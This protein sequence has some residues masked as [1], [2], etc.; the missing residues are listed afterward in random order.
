[1]MLYKCYDPFII[2]SPEQCI[3]LWAK[4]DK[5]ARRKCADIHKKLDFYNAPVRTVLKDWIVEEYFVYSQCDVFICYPKDL[6]RASDVRIISVPFEISNV[7]EY[8]MNQLVEMESHEENFREYVN[9]KS[10]NMSFNERFYIDS[11]GWIFDPY[12]NSDES[13]DVRED[14]KVRILEENSNIN[15]YMDDLWHDNVHDF[16]EDNE[17]YRDIFIE[18]ITTDAEPD[19]LDEGFYFYVCKELMEL[20]EWVTY[21]DIRK[22]DIVA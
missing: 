5:V 19:I 6:D 21:N 1:M 14:I 7:E 18:Y 13:V 4:N 3:A 11:E 22:V 12:L 9:D 10:V 8:V 17:E 16:F 20:G 15:R 2:E